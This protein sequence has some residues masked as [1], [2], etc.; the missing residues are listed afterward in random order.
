VKHLAPLTLIA[1]LPLG[2]L[3]CQKSPD[4]ASPATTSSTATAATPS[5]QAAATGLPASFH[6]L[7]AKRLDGALEPLSTYKGKVALVVNTASECGYTPQYAGLQKLYEDLSPKGLVVLGFP[8]N[9][10]GG[11]E[12]GSSK[13][14]ATFCSTKFKVTFPL[15]EKVVTKGPS[16]SPVYAFLANGFGRPEWNFHKYVVGKDGLVKRAFPSKVTPE[17]DELRKAIDEALAAPAP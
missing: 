4:T 13:E 15:F 17:S 14:I 2:G 5:T 6:A 1:L 10:F 8:S 11:Q 7:S 12:P 3:A 16:P 9:D